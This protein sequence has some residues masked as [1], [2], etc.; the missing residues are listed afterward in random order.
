MQKIPD[1][2]QLIFFIQCIFLHALNTTF[3]N[4]KAF[5]VVVKKLIVYNLSLIH[6]SEPTRRS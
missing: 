4:N 1:D 6:I 2:C 3:P 5:Y